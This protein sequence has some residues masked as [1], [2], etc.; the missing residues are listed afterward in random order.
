VRIGDTVVS[1]RKDRT[2]N[3]LL[4]DKDVADV[5]FVLDGKKMHFDIPPSPEC[6]RVVSFVR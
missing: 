3:L 1:T 2:V 4:L 6:V 5:D